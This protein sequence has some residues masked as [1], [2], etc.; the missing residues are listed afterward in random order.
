M[1]TELLPQRL[2]QL[3]SARY[4]FQR[5]GHVLAEFA[6]AIAAARLTTYRRIDHYALAWQ[7]LGQGLALGTLARESRTDRLGDG[8]LRRQFV[9]SGIGFQLFE[10]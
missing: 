2:D 3:E 4:R 7:M 10:R 1:R 5:P 6:Q 8:S 9:F